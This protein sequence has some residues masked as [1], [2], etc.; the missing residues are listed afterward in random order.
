MNILHTNRLT[1]VL[2]TAKYHTQAEAT[3]GNACTLKILCNSQNICY[4]T[5]NLISN[6]YINKKEQKKALFQC[7][8][9]CT[10]R[11]IVVG[12]KIER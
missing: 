7:S 6:K 8:L 4:Q 1:V 5:E 10:H 11:Y 9:S 3:L 2:Y 12:I